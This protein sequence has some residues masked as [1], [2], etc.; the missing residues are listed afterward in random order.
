MFAPPVQLFFDAAVRFVLV[1]SWNHSN[2][3]YSHQ[4]SQPKGP[5]KYSVIN[6]RLTKWTDR[7]DSDI[8]R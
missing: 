3:L 1:H 5:I 7:H 2:E 4:L 6:R 8:K